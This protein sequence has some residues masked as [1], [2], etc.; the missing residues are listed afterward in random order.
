MKVLPAKEQGK[1]LAQRSLIE[2]DAARSKAKKALAANDPLIVAARKDAAEAVKAGLAEGHYAAGRIAEE[3]GQVD[4][5]IQSYRAALKVHGDKLDAEGA[6]YSMALARA[7]LLP[8]PARPGLSAKLPLPAG[9]KVGWR[10]P[11]PYPARH[12]DDM[13]RLVLMLTLGLQAPLLPGEEPGSEEAEKR[14]DDV[15]KAAQAAP[16]TIPFNVLAQALAIKGR[17]NAALQTYVEG[18]RPMLRPEYGD[19]LVYLL[20]NDP[21]LKRPDILRIPDPLQ[22]EKHFAAGLNFYFDRAYANAEKEFLLTVENDGQDARYF[23]FLGLSRL[24]RNRR[25]DASA[26]FEAGAMLERLN[27][28]SPAAVSEALERIQ[29]PTRRIVNEVRERPLPLPER[30]E[31]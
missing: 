18:I 1:L 12:F 13:K 4:A 8:R 11:A 25:R 6:R 28:P 7:L 23:Y 27:R 21:R 5:A 16:G 14:A 17:W 29:G 20:R 9:E 19:G 26:D 31:R 22:A 2:L 24:A 10:D 30:R 15:L 3:L